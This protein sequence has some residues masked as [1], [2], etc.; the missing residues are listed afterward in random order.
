[1]S[2]L[3]IVQQSPTQRPWISLARGEHLPA[4][5][6]EVLYLPTALKYCV[7]LALK[8]GQSCSVKR[9]RGAWA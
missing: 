1:M 3:E 4:Q 8:R 9:E 5:E 2:V 6:V 7:E